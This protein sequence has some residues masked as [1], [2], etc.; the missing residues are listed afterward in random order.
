MVEMHIHGRSVLLVVQVLN[1]E[2]ID[3]HQVDFMLFLLEW[4]SLHC[5]VLLLLVLSHT[6][7]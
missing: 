6:H 7:Q 4:F 2:L 5:W 3:S 1:S